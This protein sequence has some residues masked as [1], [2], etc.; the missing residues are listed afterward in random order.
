MLIETRDVFDSSPM[1]PLSESSV[2]DATRWAI[3]KLTGEERTQQMAILPHIQP[4]LYLFLTDMCQF[5]ANIMMGDMEKDS[6][7]NGAVFMQKAIEN[8]QIYHRKIPLSFTE[9]PIS[10]FFQDILDVENN[11][12]EI[13]NLK[14]LCGL[15]SDEWLTPKN[16]LDLSTNSALNCPY[17]SR[18]AYAA[19][20]QTHD[21]VAE[22]KRDEKEVESALV[23]SHIVSLLGPIDGFL[24]GASDVYGIYKKMEMGKIIDKWIRSDKAISITR[25]V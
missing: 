1:L 22:L 4:D 20:L 3:A 11:H 7:M 17:L 23:N 6:Y 14:E 18:L 12:F 9:G 10:G 8:N 5:R 21:N 19:R 24:F 2:S 16:F 15:E 13:E 25:K